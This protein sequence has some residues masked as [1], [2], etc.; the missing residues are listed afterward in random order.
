MLFGWERPPTKSRLSGPDKP[1]HLD[2]VCHLRTFF[3][4]SMILY[5]VHGFA[6]VETFYFRNSFIICVGGFYQ[7][8]FFRFTSFFSN[9]IVQNLGLL[10]I[11]LAH[12]IV[13][14]IML[15]K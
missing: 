9:F 4:S 14:V 3:A 8:C 10:S 12:F 5:P 13:K 6:F 1:S 15:Y 2:S 11:V 7:S